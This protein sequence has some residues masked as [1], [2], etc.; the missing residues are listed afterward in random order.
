MINQT[1]GHSTPC[2]LRHAALT[3]TQCRYRRA[4]ARSFN[5]HIDSC[6]STTADVMYS[7]PVLRAVLRVVTTD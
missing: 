4:A 1:R 3:S 5:V 7:G 2:N 6:T